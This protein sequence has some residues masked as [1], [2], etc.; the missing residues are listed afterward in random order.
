MADPDDHALDVSVGSFIGDVGPALIAASRGIDGADPDLLRRSVVQEA[1]NLAAGFIDSDGLQTDEELWAFITTFAPM[2]ETE[3]W[4][5][6]PG[7]V[8]KA[9][10]VTGKRTFLREPST[11]FEV[12]VAADLRDGTARARTYYDRAMAVGHAVCSLDELTS[13]VE[14]DALDRFRTMLVK[15]L[16]AN[17]TAPRPAPAAATKG[18]P[19]KAPVAPTRSL[20]DVLA[21]LRELV[22]LAAVKAEVELIADLIYVQNLRRERALPVADHS[23]HLVFTGNPGT[24]KTTVARLLAEI[25]RVLGAVSTGQ[26]IETDRSQL[27]AGFVGQTATRVREVV[28]Q[29]LGG[30][31]LI[32]EAYALARG[33]E[34]DFG[35]EAIDTLVKLIEDHRDNLV[36]VVAGYPEEMATLIDA[37]PGLRSRFPKTIHFPDYTD[38]ELVQIF[39]G[40]CE[41]NRYRC[42]PETL[43]AVEGWFAAQPR[44]RGFG[45]ARLARNLF[46]ATVAR[47]ASRIRDLPAS[48]TDDQLIDLLPADLAI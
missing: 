47:Q 32:D 28:E 34:K 22:G 36:V 37:N 2:Y 9:G 10:L 6:T 17:A 8:R 25:Y 21:E 26:L 33:D 18:A 35:R 13:H 46:E 31:L 39:C 29:A 41:R 16:D 3:L 42:S 4:K 45:N 7:D 43:A 24:G 40:L 38:D 14:L 1:Y 23:L 12:L 44:D 20:E 15:V 19:P 5:A 27:V 11:L 48:P 30:V